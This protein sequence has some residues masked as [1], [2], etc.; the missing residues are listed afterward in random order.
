MQVR[1]LAA[2][3]AL[4]V[5]LAI[6]LSACGGGNSGSGSS[7]DAIVRQGIGDPEHLV[8]SNTVESNGSDVLNALFTPL[9][10]FDAD[11]KPTYDSAAGESVTT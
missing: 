10:N 7:S 5:A 6:G 8:P 4:P 11:G 9:V 3:T 1:R 2:W